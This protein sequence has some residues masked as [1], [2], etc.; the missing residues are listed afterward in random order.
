MKAEELR[1]GNWIYDKNNKPQQVDEIKRH[2]S[3]ERD[4]A[5]IILFKG[6]NFANGYVEDMQPIPLTPEI[7]EKCGFVKE[8]ITGSNNTYWYHYGELSYN[9]SHQGWWYKG[10]FRDIHFLH[11]LQNIVHSLT[12][13]EL[14]PK[15]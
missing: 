1:I 14:N 2:I 7:L 10:R 8:L 9:E 3:C 11:D 4:Y 5:H 12:Q 6:F 15:L 13:T